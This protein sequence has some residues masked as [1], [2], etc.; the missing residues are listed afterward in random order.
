M[1]SWRFE[2][3][4]VPWEIA[5]LE[6]LPGDLVT[7]ITARIEQFDATYSRFRP[8]SLV[9]TMA[10]EAGRYEFP[11]DITEL[12][13]YYLRLYQATHGAISPLVA[14][15]LD[16][17]GYDA[18]YRLIPEPGGPPAIAPLSDMLSLEGLHLEAHRPVGIDI[19]ALGKGFLVDQLVALLREASVPGGVVDA[20]GDLCHFGGEPERVGLEHPDDPNR[21][22]GVVELVNQ[23]LAA[24]SAN[25]RTWAPG[26]HHILDA[27]TGMPTT[28]IAASWVITPECALADGLAT[29]LFVAEPAQ[30][31]ECFSF[32]WMV[33]DWDGRVRTSTDFPGEV[34]Q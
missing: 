32:H 33:I 19:G 16:H 26:I 18:N 29:A 7:A 10:Q 6:E 11:S 9:S 4:G 34:F 27:L 23:S 5:T 12:F 1:A 31:E 2:A 13:E 28:S 25:R 8:D 20:S 17:W 3:I 24:S 30:L 15:A 22:V 21:V 14:P